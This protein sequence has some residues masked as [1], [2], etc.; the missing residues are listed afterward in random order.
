MKRKLWLDVPVLMCVTGLLSSALLAAE[1]HDIAS[2][3]EQAQR[4]R[5]QRL[6]W[7]KEARFGLFVHWG[8]YAIPANEWK[9][10]EKK[11]KPPGL[12]AEWIMY[13]ARIPVAEYEQ[14]A[15]DFNP[16]KFNADE[17]V[18]VARD[19]GMK[20]IVIT[21]KHCD[22]FAMYASKDTP[23]NIVDAT[24][25]KRDPLM[26][27]KKACDG[28]G[29]RLGYY[30]SHSWDWHEPDALGYDNNW[31]FP[32]RAKKD[33]NRYLRGKSLPQVEELLTRYEPAVLW[34]DVPYDLTPEHSRWFLDLIRSKYP[35]CVVNSRIGNNLGDYETPEQ[36]IPAKKSGNTF[37]VC[38]TTNNHWGYDKNDHNWKSPKTIIH[39]L[40]DIVGK[41]G[42]YL[43]NVGPTAE[44]VFPP[45]AIRL[46][47]D[48]GRWMKVNGESIYGTQASPLAPPAWGRC[49]AKPDR[50]YLHVFDWPV[51]GRLIVPGLKTQIVKAHLLADP[52]RRTLEFD[53]VGPDDLA[54][55][56]PDRPLDP[57][58][59]VV[60]I[61]H[62]GSV[63][64]NPIPLVLPDVEFVLPA[65]MAA[66]HGTRVTYVPNHYSLPNA[67]IGTWT[68]SA[69]HV[70]WEF[71]TLSAAAHEVIATY[72]AEDAQKGN[73]FTVE[74]AG[75][76]IEV[77]VHSTGDKKDFQ[78]F[79]LGTVKL[80]GP[81]PCSLTIRPK[82]INGKT[83]LVN[84]HA[85]SLKPTKE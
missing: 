49:T 61:E 48:V 54:I 47:R 72:S 32:D 81:A 2:L 57:I 20:Y 69:D 15:K 10:M 13:K 51:G 41:G 16:V 22:G 24:P 42:N 38:M 8:L 6:A 37:E 28:K 55:Q 43:L 12:G 58:D 26:E 70:T 40:V 83:S 35:D 74:V 46:L 29:M 18:D 14:L 78:A 52:K 56:V 30:Y 33:F 62:R 73:A 1:M 60:V 34:F 45:E 36:F 5:D 59:T 82:T 4:Q 85:I 39:N 76:R 65:S 3:D 79:S 17:W 7:W 68:E 67:H 44:G 25:F 19:A 63:E 53:S 21:A 50:L 75:Q 31:D 23:Y 71:R 66:L 64:T 80:P 77:K 84:L 11:N 27:L 9:G